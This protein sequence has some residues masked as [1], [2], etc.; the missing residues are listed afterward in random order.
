MVMTIEQELGTEVDDFLKQIS[1]SED[2][3]LGKLGSSARAY[4]AGFVWFQRYLSNQNIFPKIKNIHTFYVA[5][6]ADKKKDTKSFPDRKL[7]KE[8]STYLQEKEYAPKT[9]RSYC[10][11]IQSLFKCLDEIEVTTNY[12]DLPPASTVNPKFPWKL[13][14]VGE[15]L[16]D[17]DSPLYYCLGVWFLQSGLSNIDLLKLT[18]GKVKQ[19]YENDISPFCLNLCR[20]KTKK[21]QIKFRTFIGDQGIEAFRE[22]YESLPYA[23]SDDSKVFCSAIQRVLS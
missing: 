18:Y 7:L 11:A 9:V 4:K 17:F 21:Y 15:F 20:W 8:F 19:Q 22:Y 12:S 23:L 6:K 3:A 5:V 2:V 16:K 1:P 10:G 14:Q 13:Q